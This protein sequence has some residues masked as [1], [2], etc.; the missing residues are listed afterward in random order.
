MQDAPVYYLGW[1]TYPPV[2]NVQDF[3]HAIGWR[4]LNDQLQRLGLMNHLEQSWLWDSP[5]FLLQAAG[6][7]RQY[8]YFLVLDKQ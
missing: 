3:S 2:Q 7:T 8:E 1:R 6:Q 5:D 4:Y